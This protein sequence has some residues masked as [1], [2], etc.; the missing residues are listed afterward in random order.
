MGDYKPSNRKCVMY[1]KTM[2]DLGNLV[3]KLFYQV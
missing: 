3:M 2:F 1:K